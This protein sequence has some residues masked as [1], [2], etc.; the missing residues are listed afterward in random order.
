MLWYR[1]LLAHDAPF[2]QHTSMT[3]SVNELCNPSRYSDQEWLEIHRNLESYSVDK[4]V[5]WHTNGGQI[6][7]KGWEWTQCIYALQQLGVVQ[8]LSRRPRSGS[9]QGTV[10]LLFCRSRQERHRDRFV[11]QRALVAPGWTGV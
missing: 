9:G 1:T 11:W 10:D 7:R 6:Y 4:H 2:S 8:F 5:F 3:T